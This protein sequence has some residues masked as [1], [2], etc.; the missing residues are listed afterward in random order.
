M[1]MV[2]ANGLELVITVLSRLMSYRLV[3]KTNIP[4]I[5]IPLIRCSGN[6]SCNALTETNH[7]LGSVFDVNQV[8]NF[9]RCVDAL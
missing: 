6:F 8:Y 7:K 4:P 2:G 5:T 9:V 3:C 1:K